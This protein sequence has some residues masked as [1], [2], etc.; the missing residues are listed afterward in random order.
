MYNNDIYHDKLSNIKI[1][2]WKLGETFF[3]SKNNFLTCIDF[4][5][6]SNQASLVA[7][8]IKPN[9]DFLVFNFINPLDV[10]LV[11]DVDPFSPEHNSIL[12]A[13]QYTVHHARLF[14]HHW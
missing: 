13:S 1:D 10:V 11:R 14:S 8:L 12:S 2:F 9:E 3:I 4:N 6:F 5:N 7:Q